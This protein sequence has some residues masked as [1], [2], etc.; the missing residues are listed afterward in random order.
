MNLLPANSA[1]I[2]VDVQKMFENPRWGNRNNPQ[3]EENIASLIEKWRET[4]R[5]II[6][7][8]HVEGSF[9][10]AYEFKDFIKP[11]PEETI[12]RKSVNSSFIGTNLE[13]SL[14]SREIDTVVIVGL[15]TNHCVETTTRMAGNLGFNTF[16][17]SDATATF[18]RLGPDG[19]LY[20]AETIHNM[21]LV[22]LNEE[23]AT[24]VTTEQVI[25]MCTDHIQSQIHI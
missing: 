24:I 5:P 11:L 7:I 25:N 4:K 10:P 6:H 18:D 2:I 8:Q 17:V 20:T 3:A 1:L 9:H 21:T 13:S 12:I 15:T 22:N 14:R 16:L 23:F 19:K